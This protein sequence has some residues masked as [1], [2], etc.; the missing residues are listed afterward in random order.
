MTI[1]MYEDVCFRQFL[2]LT[3]LRPVATLRSGIVPLY[4]RAHR[5]FPDARL[6]LV[7]RDDTSGFTAQLN[8]DIPVN[9]IKR[10]ENEDVLFVNGRIRQWG[11]LP[12]LVSQA[13]L[14]MRFIDEKGNLVAVL[15][16]APLVNHTSKVTTASEYADVYGREAREI[17][18]L[19]STATL[20]QYVWELVEDIDREVTDD[21]QHVIRSGGSTHLHAG[22]SILNADDVALGEGVV[23]YP[24]AVIDATKGPVFIG[25]N[26]RIEA[27]AA[28]YGPCAVGADCL[29][30]AG[31]FAGSSI[32]P[33]CRVGGEVE[34]S[35]FQSYVN[36]Y[37]AG[38]I[39]HS[40]V[41]S[42][43]NFGAM[44]TNSDL[45]NNY[46][47]IRVQVDG[48][49]TDSGSI[50]V[51]SFI[52]DH[53][54]FG[55]GT[56]L[57]TGIVLGV[58]CNVF[59][60][61]LVSDKDVPSFRWGGSAGWETHQFDKAMETAA[62]TAER[63]QQKLSDIERALLKKVCDGVISSDGCLRFE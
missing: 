30:T 11:N 62:R 60:G 18:D 2:P 61:V 59:G 13:R 58:C 29:I 39:G 50:K 33:N 36:K 49:S 15:F 44:T 5:Y 9:I 31:K 55:I 42:W 53:T 1:C 32:G 20:Y 10:D 47:T 25:A 43:V 21:F 37:H 52:G 41:G 54:K 27:H 24:G 3:F 63:R 6:V 38:F 46:S 12:D 34:A 57:T 26:T 35:V 23:V 7:V 16:R 40:Y 4:Q 45:K 19:K 48:K 17:P 8:P 56:L 22:S 14:S 28:I 51:G